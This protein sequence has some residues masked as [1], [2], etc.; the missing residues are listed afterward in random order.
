MVKVVDEL[1]MVDDDEYIAQVRGSNRSLCYG[2]LIELMFNN[3][4]NN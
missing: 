4:N 3:N 1:A 2:F